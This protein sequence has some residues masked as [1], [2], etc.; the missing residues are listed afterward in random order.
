MIDLSMLREFFRIKPSGEIADHTAR[1][2]GE[3]NEIEITGDIVSTG[4]IKDAQDT[5]TTL[6]VG[7]GS[8]SVTVVRRTDRCSNRST[9]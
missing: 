8:V 6:T 1:T 9:G 4:T 7:E 3:N 2:E 5:T